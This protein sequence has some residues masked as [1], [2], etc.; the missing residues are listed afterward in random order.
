[1]RRWD[2]FFVW[3][4][5]VVPIHTTVLN[6]LSFPQL[7]RLSRR[8]SVL[9]TEGETEPSRTCDVCSFASATVRKRCKTEEGE[10][11]MVPVSSWR[12]AFV[13]EVKVKLESH[14]NYTKTPC[15]PSH[16][17]CPLDEDIRSGYLA[18]GT[19]CCGASCSADNLS[20]SVVN[21]FKSYCF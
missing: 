12:G 7:Y 8:P 16:S 10:R 2:V 9:L 15:V 3:H 14:H 11:Q 20:A 18:L 17:S 19:L 21:T 1:M 4:Q 6:F 13:S 5:P